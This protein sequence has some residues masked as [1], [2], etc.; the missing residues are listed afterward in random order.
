M[1]TLLNWLCS[2]PTVWYTF[3]HWQY[4]VDDTTTFRWIDAQD[5][6]TKNEGDLAV[7]R[8]AEENKFIWNL[9]SRQPTVAEF[10]AWLGFQRKSDL[11]LYWIDDT[12]LEGRYSDWKSGQPDNAG[13]GENCGNIVQGGKWNDLRCDSYKDV[14]RSPVVL[15]QRPIPCMLISFFTYFISYFVP[16]HFSASNKAMRL[17]PASKSHGVMAVPQIGHLEVVFSLGF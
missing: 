2:E 11:K 4:Y 17:K 8:T 6:C 10:G 16:L 12:P 15:C 7:I 5:V 9:I 14:Y 13:H 1:A 3:G